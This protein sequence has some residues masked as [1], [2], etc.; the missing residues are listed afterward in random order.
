LGQ[1]RTK[2]GSQAQVPADT[3]PM[4]VQELREFSSSPLISIGAH[5]RS[6]CY[7]PALDASEQRR[8]IVQSRA[9]CEALTGKAPTSF[10]YPY[11]GVSMDAARL[12]AESGFSLAVTTDT[13]LVWAG[14]DPRRLPRLTVG[15]WDAED[16]ERRLRRWVA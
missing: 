2:L 5:S 15:N 14:A 10:A 4:T 3:R 7:L 11:G 12:V 16:F 9:E 1:L 8:E 6:H 13:D